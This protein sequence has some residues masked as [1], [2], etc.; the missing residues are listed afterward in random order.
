MG[1]GSM[2]GANSSL[3]NNRALR[4]RN[5]LFK[6]S[7]KKLLLVNNQESEAKQELSGSEKR[8]TMSSKNSTLIR[9]TP[10]IKRLWDSLK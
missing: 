2:A 3:K 9:R 5:S 8:M 1:S 10:F 4:R 6:G 7:S